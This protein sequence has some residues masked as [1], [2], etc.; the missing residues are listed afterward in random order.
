VDRT[1]VDAVARVVR[2]NLFDPIDVNTYGL[3]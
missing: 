1:D 2:E 3:N